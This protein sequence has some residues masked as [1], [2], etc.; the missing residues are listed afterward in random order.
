MSNE[1]SAGVRWK[2]GPT[3]HCYH[4]RTEGF[5]TYPVYA[6]ADY[7]NA[8][9]AEVKALRRER[10]DLQAENEALHEERGHF[11][12]Q[13]VKD[14]NDSLRTRAEDAERERDELRATVKRQ[15]IWAQAGLIGGADKENGDK[16]VKINDLV[17]DL[18]RELAVL[19][20]KAALA[21]EL[22]YRLQGDKLRYNLVGVPKVF[23]KWLMDYNAL[24]AT[25]A[26]PAGEEGSS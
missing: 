16:L 2:Q 6:N 21:D 24:A 18:E 19:R 20:P 23:V 26:E 13:E 22:A 7:L 15:L 25:A 14:E 3:G 8:L 10:D 11:K 4:E 1:E 9:E 12:I 17:G 5:I